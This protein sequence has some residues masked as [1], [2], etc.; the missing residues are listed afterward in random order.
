MTRSGLGRA[1]CSVRGRD[2][3]GPGPSGPGQ[4][5]KQSI[6]L[7]HED[8]IEKDLA[9]LGQVRVR[10]SIVLSQEDRIERDLAFLDQVR[11]SSRA[12]CSARRTG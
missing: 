4:G 6:V 12:L 8:R 10:Q 3:E 9:L 5:V 11:G 1:L 2:R 7:S